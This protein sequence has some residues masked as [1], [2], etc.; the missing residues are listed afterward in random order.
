MEC[1]GVEPGD[2]VACR[3]PF[4]RGEDFKERGQRGTVNK[5]NY[6]ERADMAQEGF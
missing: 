3:A 5:F 2:G 1:G 4:Q 6:A